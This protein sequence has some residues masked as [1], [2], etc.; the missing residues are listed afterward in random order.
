MRVEGRRDYCED[1]I[2]VKEGR[3]CEE[4]SHMRCYR[5][6]LLQFKFHGHG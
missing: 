5:A 2:V 4:A 3:Q 1:G 6:V